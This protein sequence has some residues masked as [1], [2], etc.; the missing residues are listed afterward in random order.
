[1]KVTL[2]SLSLFAFAFAVHWLSLR[3]ARPRRGL[4]FLLGLFTATL[5]TGLLLALAPGLGPWWP[6][7]FWELLHVSIFYIAMMLAYTVTCTALLDSSPTLTLLMFLAAARSEGRSRAELAAL[8]SNDLIV[9]RRFENMLRSGVIRQ[10][11]PVFELT[12]KGRF[13]ARFFGFFR[14]LYRMRQGG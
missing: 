5:V 10:V 1:M 4:L 11:G 7:G 8:F 9:G 12:P 6:T 2:F 3:I 14:S 13:W